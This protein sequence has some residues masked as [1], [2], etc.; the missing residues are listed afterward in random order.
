[1]TVH[2][3]RQMTGK[4]AKNLPSVVAAATATVAAI[5]A[6]T[7]SVGAIDAAIAVA[8]GAVSVS[9]SAAVDAGTPPAVPEASQSEH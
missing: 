1:M 8:P 2:P 7:A 5:A 9:A 4:P 3:L 6:V